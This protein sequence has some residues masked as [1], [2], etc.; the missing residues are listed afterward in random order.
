MNADNVKV[1]IAGVNNHGRTMLTAI[2]E[3]Q[4]LTLVSCFDVD[5]DAVRKTAGE[6]GCVPVGSFEELLASGIDAVVLVT[7]NYLHG[8]QVREALA[9]GKHVFVEKPLTPDI[10]EGREILDMLVRSKAIVQ[11]GHNTRKRAV[12]RKAREIVERGVLGRV[13]SC[14]AHFSYDAG[15]HAGL[16]SWKLDP[17]LCPLL[18]LPQLGIHFIDVLQYLVAAIHEVSCFARSAV[19]KDENGRDIV[20][21]TVSMMRFR[22]GVTGTL[23][24]H[25]VVPFTFEVALYGTR[26]NL[27]CHEDSL[28]ST[29]TGD[30]EFEEEIIPVDEPPYA[31][32]IAELREFAECIRHNRTPEVDAE[33]GLRNVAVVEAMKR[34]VVEGRTIK[35]EEVRPAK[36]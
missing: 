7:P 24:A 35:V 22:N 3:C 23:H 31:S 1:G 20:D 26:A 9:A 25:Y 29:S 18:P 4:A 28:S 13:V 27:V 6:Y 11:V 5:A 14:H 34:S 32:F 12:F 19:M 21:S 33:T 16:P 10:A 8:Q 2:R 15:L 30:F 17:T 36:V